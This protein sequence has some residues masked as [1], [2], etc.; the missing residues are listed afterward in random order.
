MR[1]LSYIAIMACS[2][3]AASC[4][5]DIVPKGQSTLQKTTDLELML[6]SK[7]IS[8]RPHETLGLVV[9]EG[10]GSGFT[11]IKTPVRDKKPKENLVISIIFRIF[12]GENQTFTNNKKRLPNDFKGQSYRNFLYY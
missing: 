1:K 10:Y 6:N 12:V 2:L 9:N 8:G 11:T 7:T 3:L 5:M 4:D